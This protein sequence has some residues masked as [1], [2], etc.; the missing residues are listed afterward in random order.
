MSKFSK[1][2]KKS[3]PKIGT[4][5]LPDIVFMLLFFFM[6]TTTMRDVE[7]KIQ[8]PQLPRATEIKKIENKSLVSY[9]YIAPPKKEYA[10]KMGSEPRLQLNGEF[11]EISEIGAFVESQR[12]KHDEAEQT[13]LW[14]ALKVDKNTKMGIV[15]D[16][17]TELRKNSALKINYSTLKNNK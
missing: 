14:W 1:N 12:G 15:G 2:K 3:V 17:K 5:S 4:E 10:A 16:V 6:V 7:L 11:S 13:K 9:L 8:K